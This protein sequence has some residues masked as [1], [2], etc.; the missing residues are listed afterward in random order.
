MISSMTNVGQGWE[1][2]ISSM[3]NVGQ[4]W[5]V[6]IS[7]MANKKSI[8]VESDLFGPALTV[9]DIL[10]FEIFNLEE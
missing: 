6:M 3:T 1:V 7:S 8:T 4:G 2:M 10:T 5:E 9:S